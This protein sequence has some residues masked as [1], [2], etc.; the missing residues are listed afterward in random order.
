[1][2][3]IFLFLSTFDQWVIVVYNIE[4]MVKSG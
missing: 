3:A 1:M 4:A 2:K